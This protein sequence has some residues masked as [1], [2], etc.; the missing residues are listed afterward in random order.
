MLICGYSKAQSGQEGHKEGFMERAKHAIG[1]DKP[2][3]EEKK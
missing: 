3:S 2:K 1:M